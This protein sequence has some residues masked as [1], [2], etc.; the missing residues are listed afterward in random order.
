MTKKNKSPKKTASRRS[1][2][3][4]LRGDSEDDDAKP[5][6][7]TIGSASATSALS[8]VLVSSS[9]AAI[10]VGSGTASDATSTAAP[11]PVA[12]ATAAPAP[13][14]P[15]SAAVTTVTP[16]PATPPPVASAHVAAH[17]PSIADHQ[18]VETVAK[19]CDKFQFGSGDTRTLGSR[20]EIWLEQFMLAVDGARLNDK[21]LVKS[22]F[23]SQMG[24]EA[25]RIFK[26]LKKSDNSDTFD[27]VVAIMNKQLIQRGSEFAERVR[28][29]DDSN[30]RFEGESI[31]K[32]VLR[33]RELATHCNYTDGIDKHVLQALVVGC[34]IP[35]F[36]RKVCRMSEKG[37][38]LAEAIEL[39]KGFEREDADMSALMPGS[40]NN[41]RSST[42]NNIGST[43][44][45]NDMSRQQRPTPNKPINKSAPTSHASNEQKCGN[46]GRDKHVSMSECPARGQECNRCH[47]LNH[48]GRLCR[49]SPQQQQAQSGGAHSNTTKSARFERHPNAMN[50][51]SSVRLH[52]VD[53]SQG[54]H[55]VD[56]DQYKAFLRYKEMCDNEFAAVHE[57]P[58]RYNSG[59][60]A[61]IRVC[62]SSVSFLVD[63][64][65]PVNVIDEF[66]YNELV[67][68][69]QLLPCSAHYFGF[70]SSDPME[71]AGQFTA[72]IYFR[73]QSLKAG[74][75]VKRGSSERLLCFSTSRQLGIVQVFN[76]LDESSPPH[77][78]QAQTASTD[79]HRLSTE[80]LRARFP[81]A[82]SGR[83]GRIK[84]HQVTLDIDSAVR[85][86]AQKLRPVAFHLRDA[87]S[88]ELD[89]QV[90]DGILE[91]VDSSMGPTPWISNLVVVP[92]SNS[93]QDVSITPA[94]SALRKWTPGRPALTL[95]PSPIK[96]R[97]T[98]DS[99][100]LNKAVKR[101]R[102]P[103]KTLDDIILAVNGATIFSKL[104]LNKAFH[105]LELAEESRQATTITTHKGLFRYR[106]L[107]M[108]IS[109]ASEIFTDT[110]RSILADC[111]GQLNMTDDI[112]V[113]GRTQEEHQQHLLAVL[114]K[115]ETH[116]IT[117]NVDKCELYRDE[118]VF[119]GMH[120]S[121][122]GASPT[123]D[124]CKALKEAG[125]P[126][127]VSEL[128][129][130]LGLAQYSA[131]FIRDMAT[132]TEPLWRLTKNG[133]KWSWTDVEQR[134]FDLLKNA[135]S[136]TCLGYF[137]PSW[138]TEVVV[139]ASPVGLGAVLA[140]INP[141]D[142]RDRQVICYAS[143]MLTDT[144]RRY[145]QCEKEAL[146]AVWGCER[147]WLYLF[148][149]VF[150]LVTDNRAVQLIFGNTASK[151]PAR[152][153]RW[154]LR[155][156]Q[157]DFN[158]VHR[159]GKDNVAD[160]FSRHPDKTV[161][162]EALAA[163]QRS[164]RYI[165]AVVTNALPSAI[166]RKEVAKATAE[167]A[168]LQ[169]LSKWL[170]RS[171]RSRL[172]AQLQQY[173]NELD[174]LSMTSD[175]ILLRD[176]LIVVP[177][178][179]RARVVE[180][181]H[182]GHQGVSQTKALIRSRVWYPGIDAQVERTVRECLFCQTYSSKRSYEPLQP[183][184][185][186]DGPWQMVSGD[187]C[188]PLSDN[189]Y[190]LVTTCLYS[191]W[192]DVRIVRSTDADTVVPQ[193]EE[194][195]SILGTPHVYCT[196]NG[197]P[198]FSRAFACFA[199][200]LGFEH[201]KVTPLWPRANGAVESIMKKLRRVEAIAVQ[202]GLSRQHVLRD[203]LRAYRDTPHTSTKVPPADLMFG[204]GRT[205]GIPRLEPSELQR[206]EWHK[207]ARANDAATKERM[208]NEYNA[209]MR[210][211]ESKLEIG[212]R[213]LLHVERTRKA[214]TDWSPL[215]Y[216]VTHI[217]GAM[218]T[219]ARPGHTTTR[220]SSFFKLLNERAS[221]EH[222][223]TD[224]QP[225]N[226]ISVDG[227]VQAS[228]VS[229]DGQRN[230]ISTTSSTATAPRVSFDTAATAAPKRRVGRP[231]RAEAAAYKS[232]ATTALQSTTEPIR[233]SLRI[234][235]KSNI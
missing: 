221:S 182:T 116:G 132:I 222:T 81:S 140:Q 141:R 71:L 65:A 196:D 26:T 144:E 3:H 95:E 117:L 41:S 226:S 193:L 164:E 227:P 25:Y 66:T 35:A 22:V 55:V 5:S 135:I 14:A 200:R 48:Y 201:R 97:L 69:P 79:A 1:H 131:R 192:F 96:V 94:V 217:N 7:T 89:T 184:P 67:D 178:K 120:F 175:G 13:V 102:F 157:F 33:L 2:D 181:A 128:R 160:F 45:A 158:I 54:T 51:K 99:K 215:P 188:G 90:K 171:D 233:S 165:N 151:P 206:N 82:F 70:G 205:S 219:A 88:A 50:G 43:R 6:T 143:R 63:T 210:T 74:F 209:H 47:K 53:E 115:L 176:S 162:V 57:S 107:H 44:Q 60:R 73:G 156:T 167:D 155:L 105:Q 56:A 85:P 149:Q 213:V 16:A 77:P 134:A 111:Q 161:D 146:A 83:L 11:A 46:C 75:I 24:T 34:R 183:T 118:L 199:E 220:N 38:S 133:V 19:L 136:T 17:E 78:P 197:P 52:N 168:E 137:D 124:R 212:S 31:E 9:T 64:G 163:Q 207:I 12:P 59:P 109:S 80:Q 106:R 138:R 32:F 154:A 49:S 174:R 179:L 18:K 87:V 114:E 23:L 148:G 108:G 214:D 112:L 68:K 30:K 8:A 159:P 76:E 150:T 211:R 187:F 230:K 104:D 129:S 153:E 121:A 127:N 113:F 40:R 204:F 142:E 103:I 100:A 37:P 15:V 170:V 218:I 235:A 147:F 29:F 20:W 229:G 123:H 194:L 166:T 208:Q 191:R 225:P 86:V 228:A 92:K 203:L 231:T 125:P 189:S 152:I 101:Q 58:R 28:M 119:F 172:P 177:Q 169:E 139:D 91:R 232:T 195:F 39:A 185:M 186:P 98:C 198:F 62:G 180:L 72:D 122:K 216:T 21:A 190:Y 84:G 173:K 223:G 42:I 145:S 93:K 61:S 126:S 110:I 10:T 202:S 234:S 224:E 4:Y 36:T 27:E 130:L